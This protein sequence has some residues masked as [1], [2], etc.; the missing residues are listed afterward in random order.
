MEDGFDG[1]VDMQGTF[2]INSYNVLDFGNKP[3]PSIE[4]KQYLLPQ[5]QHHPW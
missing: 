5:W 4:R 3:Y 2:G 1:S